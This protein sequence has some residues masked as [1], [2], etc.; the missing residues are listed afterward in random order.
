MT[1]TTM[2]DMN[3]PIKYY[4]P[5][6]M[7]EDMGERQRLLTGLYNQT[8]SLLDEC[9]QVLDTPGVW[10]DGEAY[11]LRM[12]VERRLIPFLHAIEMVMNK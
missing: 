9:A 4:P 7:R 5:I 1:E 8:A 11:G 10:P 2:I 12:Q 3:Q 6:P